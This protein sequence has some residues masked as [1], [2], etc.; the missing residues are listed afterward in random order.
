ML[1]GELYVPR[2]PSMRIV[3]LAEALAPQ[4]LIHE[5]GV[6]PGEKLHEEMIAADD[7]HRT[8]GLA[9]RFV[10]MPT[11]ATWGYVPPQSG[12]PVSEDFSYRSNTNDMWLSPSDLRALLVPAG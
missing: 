1:G 2:I 10:V 6:R 4:C 3:D 8:V 7:S 5:I 12:K 11:I 9:D